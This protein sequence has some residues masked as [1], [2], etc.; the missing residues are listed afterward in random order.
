MNSDIRKVLEHA[1]ITAY[2]NIYCVE[3]M[4]INLLHTEK[5]FFSLREYRTLIDNMK[6]ADAK[7]SVWAKAILYIMKSQH[8]EAVLGYLFNG[9]IYQIN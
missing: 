1:P 5:D 7:P 8:S 2:G 6:K 9:K 3:G 4:C